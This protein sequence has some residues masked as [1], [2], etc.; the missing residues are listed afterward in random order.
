MPNLLKMAKVQSILS[1]HAQG[2]S[3]RE[4]ARTLG[5]DRGT[6]HKYLSLGLYGSKPAIA[7]AGSDP[8]KPAAPGIDP[9][10]ANAPIGITTGTT[11]DGLNAPI[12]GL[13]PPPGSKPANAP[14]GPPGPQ[15]R[16]EP[17]R[18]TIR[19]KATEGLSAQ[20]I[21]QDLVEGGATVSYD[22][23]RRYL[24]RLGHVR[25][26]PFRRME[27]AAGEEAQVDFG[28]GAPIVGADGKRRKTHVFRIVLSHSRKGYSEATFRQTTDDFLA[29]LEN[30][31]RH[32]G[33]VP[34]TLVIDNLKAAVKHPDWFDP[35]LTP[36]VAAFCRHH[37]T[38][39]L[40]TRPYT[41]RHKG[42]VEAGVKYVQ[43]NGLARRTFDSLA[44]QNAHLAH[45]EA[46]VAD[47]RIHGTTKQQVAKVFAAS[48]RA[49]LLPL[50]NEP[51]ANFHEA[52]R[53]VNRDGHVEVAKAYYSAP[54]EYLGRVVWVRWDA[55]LV[56]VFNQ[57]F[58]Q[59]ALHVRREPGRFSTLGEHVVA[60][61]IGG[62]ERGAA[63]LLRKIEAIGEH[64]HEWAQAMLHARGIEGTRV[65]QGL[66]ALAVKHP[67]EALDNACK[68]ALSHGV[69]R[70]RV[71][72]QLLKHHAPS[73]Q[74]LPFLDEHPIIR[75]LGDYAALVARAIHRQADRPSVG[76]GFTRHG[77][78]VRGAE[79]RHM[80]EKSSGRANDRSF[81]TF[82]TRPRSG[83]PSAGCSSAEPDSVSPD[84]STV[85][86]PQSFDQP[87]LPNQEP[88]HE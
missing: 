81:G 51:F 7:P 14:I 25:P 44:T 2:R 63:W 30:A 10:P 32:F 45:W 71:L 52:E 31:F 85:V 3:Q 35:E 58:E 5:V 38:V 9:K 16:C 68:T 6:V 50:P 41:P 20:R 54:P 80:K 21:Y 12:G 62:L 59:I 27:C 40:P 39:I 61:K 23:V 42:K 22:S 69:Y 1:L 65:L 28:T 18:E 73:Q 66:L 17:Y 43:N 49:A 11:A 56:R 36:K 77:S 4:I 55:R 53:K 67:A 78:G 83:Y 46:T 57:R 15:S 74:P 86:Q 47:T 70:L 72:R 34:K 26:L 8:S 88:P 48:E 24:R 19:A 79:D 64:A 87:L 84:N 76:E 82:S 13:P 37:G 33:G 60:E 75:P 29:A